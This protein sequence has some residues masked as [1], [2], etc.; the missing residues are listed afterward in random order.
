MSEQ[1]QEEDCCVVPGRA[2][3]LLLYNRTYWFLREP[4]VGPLAHSY[5]QNITQIATLASMERFWR[6]HSHVSVSLESDR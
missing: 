5:E 3:H 6:F 2:E 4:Q 1:Q